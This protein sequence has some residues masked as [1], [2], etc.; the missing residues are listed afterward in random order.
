MPEAEM[1]ARAAL[2]IVRDEVDE[3]L[4]RAADRL[5]VVERISPGAR[6]QRRWR[7]RKAAASRQITPAATNGADA[8]ESA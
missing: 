6:R 5:G 3:A 4:R 7:A 8:Q 1:I 2:Q